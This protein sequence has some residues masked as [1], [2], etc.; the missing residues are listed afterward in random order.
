MKLSLAQKL[1][2]V[3]EV[4]VVL[5]ATL[6][7][8]ATY[9]M[10]RR[11]L[12]ERTQ[13][14]LTSIAVLKENAVKELV[15]HAQ[16]ELIYFGTSEREHKLLVDY[17]SAKRTVSK[18]EMLDLFSEI[19]RDGHTFKDLFLL[20]MTGAVV[21]SSNPLDEGKIKSTE[22]SFVKAQDETHVE[23]F[24]HDVTIGETAMAVS[25]PIRKDGETI[26]VVVG[27]VG[28]QEISK[29]M[30]ERSGL[31]ETGETF[32]VNSS[33][34]V[35]TEL[36]KEPGLTL[37]KT[38]FLPQIRDCLEGKSNFDGEA[39]YNG[40][41]IFGYWRWF[42]EIK[43]CLVTKIDRTEA[44]SPIVQTAI[45]LAGVVLLIGVSV[46][47]LGY[48]MGK[49]M[50]MPLSKLRDEAQKIK[51]GNFEVEVTVETND[52]IGEVALAFNEMAAKLK[53]LYSGLEDRVKQKTIE[54]SNKL[55]E[56]AGLNATLGKNEAAMMNILEDEKELEKQLAQEKNGIE[57]KV[58]ERTRELSDEQ[59]KLMASISALP[60]A[61]V[62]VDLESQIV[63]Q[64]GKLESIFG[65]IDGNWSMGKIDELLGDAFALEDKLKE[66]YK[67]QKVFDVRDLSYGAKFLGIYMAP[68]LNS[69]NK[70][71]GV[72][73]TIK[74]STEAKVLIRSRDEFFSI[75]SHEL[76]T[77][78]TA[79]RG[80][81]SM[82]LDYYKEALKDP[83]LKQMVV[84]THEASI[85]LIGIVNDFLDMSRLEQGKMQYSITDVEIVE[86]VN[87]VVKDLAENAKVKGVGL[88]VMGGE[89]NVTVSADAGKVE[90]ILFNLIGNS[91]KFTEKGSVTIEIKQD[92]EMVNI[93]I[94]DTGLGIPLA[95]QGILFHKF[96]QAGSS[97]ITRDGAK[98]T[99]LGLYISRLMAEGMGGSL[100]LLKSE[101]GKGSVFGICLPIGTK[102]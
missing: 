81:T 3:I 62:I 49:M 4:V 31:G 7:G 33:N 98:G 47:V 61:F 36:L 60:R 71:I 22:L 9:L 48:V 93:V 52:E 72:V 53:E 87:K 82:I 38:L 27:R 83:E 56:L 94:V 5:F 23:G 35:V 41:V 40:D 80:N 2:L 100:S 73:I 37:K 70:L 77:P 21:I 50:M 17:L 19:I 25:K 74:D 75:A 68:V 90:Q 67:E 43:S 39:D 78:L 54:L 59:A 34:M 57:K 89:R 84:D 42:P 26:G 8:L 29:L 58:E 10:F 66:I 13:A 1:V 92:K 44:L 16:N 18:E 6:G 88:K 30:V 97:T 85:R 95:N 45:I 20:D 91:L 64:N 51:G 86:V 55:E 63:A 32:I 65:K 102:V 24:Y 101:E 99:G 12:V 28:I 76:R 15:E 14:Q 69:E 79:I 46:G 96:Q 11:S